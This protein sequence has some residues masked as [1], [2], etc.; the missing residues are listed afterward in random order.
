M[1]L[2]HISCLWMCEPC[3]WHVAINK[4]ASLDATPS[5]V[6]LH[7]IAALMPL[8][9]NKIFGFSVVHFTSVM[10]SAHS[11]EHFTV[12]L[13]DYSLTSDLRNLFSSAQ[14]NCSPSTKYAQ[15]NGQQTVGQTADGRPDGQPKNMMPSI[16]YC[17]QRCKNEGRFCKLM[18][19]TAD[20]DCSD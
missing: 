1:V 9:T 6:R 20:W 10:S 12:L 15:N 19:N 16:C 3:S 18:E 5:N 14:F 2:C 13:Y 8:L 17:W 7:L 4:Q 11:L